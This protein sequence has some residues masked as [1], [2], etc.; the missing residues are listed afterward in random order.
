MPSTLNNQANI[1]YDYTGARSAQN[2]ESNTV[3][4]TLLDEYN[5]TATKTALNN[6]FRPGNSVTYTLLIKNDGRGDVYNLNVT[7]NLG[8]DLSSKPLNFSDAALYINNVKVDVTPVINPDNSVSF[9]IPS[10]FMSGDTAMII[11]DSIVNPDL[12]PGVNSITNTANIIANG[13]SASGSIVTVNPS[14]SATINV[15]NYAQLNISKQTDKDTI[16]AGESL[17]Y[18]FT[19]NNS[20]NQ[21]ANNIV[22]ND[23]LPQNFAIN[24][25]TSTTNGITTTYAPGQYNL[26]ASTNTITLPNNSGPEIIVP[27]AINSNPGTTVIQI[28][29]IVNA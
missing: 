27:P 10:P 5:L 22:L 7:D 11:Y 6:T 19:I 25:V 21:Q 17:T 18:T 12:Q 29:G 15:E 28:T 3:R 13:G 1:S 9:Q 24:Q 14:P 4:T 2:A 23:T 20:G 26:D 8:S 16:T